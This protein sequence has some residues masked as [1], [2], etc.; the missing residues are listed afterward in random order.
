MQVSRT[1]FCRAQAGVTFLEL[2]LVVGILTA[3]S[4]VTI[5]TW[6]GHQR[7]QTMEAGARDVAGLIREAQGSARARTNGANWGVRVWNSATAAVA[8]CS[9]VVSPCGANA[10]AELFY[11]SAYS[12]G[13]VT[14][15]ATLSSGADF[16]Q[17][18]EG[19][20]L[21]TIFQSGSGSLVSG[22]MPWAMH[23]GTTDSDGLCNNS[24]AAECRLFVAQYVGGNGSCASQNGSA[25]WDCSTVDTT[26]TLSA[27]R[28][29]A[30][31][32]PSG[33]IWAVY[34]DTT[35]NG[36]V[37]KIAKATPGTAASG[38][39]A[40]N[41]TCSILYDTAAGTTGRDPTIAFDRSGMAWVFFNDAA[42]EN[43]SVARYVAA[44]GSDTNCPGNTDGASWSCGVVDDSGYTPDAKHISA[45]FDLAGN[46]W[47]SYQVNN[48]YLKVARTFSSAADSGCTGNTDALVWECVVV[49]NGGGGS[50]GEG[51]DSSIAIHPTTNKA[52]VRSTKTTTSTLEVARYVES[53]GTGCTSSAWTGCATV[54]GN[55][56]TQVSGGTIA[57]RTSES[58]A[59]M[60][61][62]YNDGTTKG[63]RL[64]KYVGAS[65]TG[66]SGTAEW[67]CIQIDGGTSGAIGQK[68]SLGFDNLANAWIAY[69][70]VPSGAGPIAALKVAKYEGTGGSG[71]ANST[72]SG[73]WSCYTVDARS[74]GGGAG[75][76][77]SAI[78]FAGRRIVLQLVTD[79]SQQRTI[80]V[81]AFGSISI[82]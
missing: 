33:H 11:G 82:E 19:Q 35:T 54:T 12:G 45:A 15:R 58:A 7:R 9:N 40:A 27:L 73:E 50:P 53:G 64:A 71:C 13:T 49:D 26:S 78:A 62:H 29:S 67:T 74:T 30:A 41:W 63:L 68:S 16:A 5:S 21:D 48:N 75:D 55:V 10:C 61:Y 32:D 39:C 69:R 2:L 66:C 46:A 34:H 6:G 59:W 36:G 76:V 25:L 37:L 31:L 38:N 1:S 77:P 4:V 14:R 52:W 70:Y 43:L 57:F 44:S 47:V 28:A 42:N 60:T 79:T 22:T 18:A 72:T 51:A 65:G 81:Q 80:T 56:D 8:S 17:P 3:V 20:C 24:N 23:L